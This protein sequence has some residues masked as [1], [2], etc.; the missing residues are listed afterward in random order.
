[1]AA[2]HDELPARRQ[3]G[4]RRGLRAGA[5]RGGHGERREAAGEHGTAM[6]SAI[7]EHGGG[8]RWRFAEAMEFAAGCK[9]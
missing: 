1:M 8:P 3:G 2:A 4:W 5:L 9:S 6:K 7:A